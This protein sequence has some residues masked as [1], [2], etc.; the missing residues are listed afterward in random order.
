[1]TLD[2]IAIL[3]YLA[4]FVIGYLLVARKRHRGA[5]IVVTLV[6]TTIV[7]YGAFT[8]S[9]EAIGELASG[10]Q[11]Q[12]TLWLGF[13]AILVLLFLLGINNAMRYRKSSMLSNKNR[14]VGN[15]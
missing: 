3:L 8:I 15:S 1:M 4:V 9:I 10:T 13:S 5:T 14:H 6:L 7:V 11:N 2:K 12:L